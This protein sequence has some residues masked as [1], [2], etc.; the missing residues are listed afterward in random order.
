MPILYKVGEIFPGTYPK[1]EGPILEMDKSGSLFFFLQFPYVTEKEIFCFKKSF[2]EYAYL[3]LF[4]EIPLCFWILKF[5]E[6]LN[7]IDVPFNAGLIKDLRI[8]EI[9]NLVNFFLLDQNILKAIKIVGLNLDF[10]KLFYQTIEKQI[11]MDYTQ[12]IFLSKVE[13][14]YKQYTSQELFDL[15]VKF[16][17][18]KQ[19]TSFD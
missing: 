4:D 1:V 12:E 7:Y 14:V 15:G 3:E 13:K 19:S 8:E 5:S 9:K 11:R 6:P 18:E 2:T 10:I 16:K 17:H